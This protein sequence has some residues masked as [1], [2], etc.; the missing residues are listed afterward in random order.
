MALVLTIAGVPQTFRAGTLQISKT[1]NGRATANFQVDSTAGTYRPAIDA[2]VIFTLD[3]DVI[4]AGLAQRPEE[5]GQTGTGFKPGIVTTLN[6]VD[7][8]AYSERRLVNGVM[9]AGTLKSLVQIVADYLNTFGVT[10][11]PAQIDGP[12]LPELIHEYLEATEVLNELATLASDAAGTPFVWSIDENKVLTMGLTTSTAAPFDI[13]TVGDTTPHVVG[14]IT[15]ITDRSHYANV[16]I[17]LVPTLVETDR[18]ETFTG[19]GS[20]VTFQLNYKMDRSYGYVTSDGIY[21]TLGLAGEGAT[22][23]YDPVG[24]TITRTSAP[25]AAAPI[26]ITMATASLTTFG[27]ASDPAEILA[28]GYW[29]RLLRVQ[30]V[31]NA[32]AAQTIAEAELAKALEMLQTVSYKTMTPGLVPGQTQTINVP[33]RNVNTTGMIT[34]VNIRDF[35]GDR[36]MYEVTVTIDGSQTNIGK[37][38]RD[39]YK[40]WSGDVAGT[41]TQNL[42]SGTPPTGSAGAAPPITSV[43]FNRN[44]VL[45]GSAGFIYY[46]GG[47]SVA[48]G[49][50]CS[51]TA[52]NPNG[53]L[54][55]GLNGTIEDP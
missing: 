47:N 38:W 49:D 44:G 36:L 10:L 37:G 4:F 15:V 14:D 45:G 35:A 9:P 7:Y 21:E 16:V 50:G 18:T 8:N 53:C 52:V 39:V 41:S 42:T 48:L 51:I 25:A 17:V 24:N 6:A 3:G 13:V 2:Q 20:T 23:T 29:E 28:V 40:Q 5:A 34:D 54:V 32:A 46:D 22:W 30:S 33:R 31:P 12:T 19:D 55:V 11:N 43:Q 26:S 1:A 27:L